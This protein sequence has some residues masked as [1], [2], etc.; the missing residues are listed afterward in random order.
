MKYNIHR[1]GTT[2]LILGAIFSYIYFSCSEPV[3]DDNNHNVAGFLHAD[4]KLIVDGNGNEIILRGMGFGG[5]MVQEP[6]MMLVSGSASAGQHTIFEDIENLIGSDNLETY[7]QTWLD[8]YCTEIDVA[9]LKQ[10]GFNSLRVAMHYNLF[11]LPIE[12]EPVYGEDT[13]LD[14]GFTMIDELLSW[15][16]S[17]RIYL[18]LDLHAAPGGQGHDAN[19][20]DYNP[21]RPS[22]WEHPQNRRKT[23]ALW[24]RLAE[25]YASEPWIGG[26][27]LINEPNWYLGDNNIM[28]KELYDDIIAEIRLVDQNHLI[29][30]EG[31]WFANDHS[32]LWPFEDDNVALSFHRYWCDNTVET[33]LGYLQMR[34]SYNVPLWMG[35]SGENNSQWYIDAVEL[36]EEYKIG[37]AWWTWKK[38]ESGTGIYSIKSPE[39]YNTLRNFWQ[40][41]GTKP[42]SAF[43]FKVMMSVAENALLK[44]CILNGETVL[45]LI[46]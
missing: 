2:I 46:K 44:N 4:G 7:H 16:E 11:T 26:Y 12:K 3:V 19:I 22:L 38:M 33:I 28:L 34:D 23:V 37:W 41:G 45:A 20:S 43:A 21:A 6:Y 1:K 9:Y 30:I 14:R 18:I 15:C 24:A 27:D 31:N 5:W 17:N 36:L 8:N 13:W 40:N 39:G 29:F 25:R 35:E 10:M 42:D 32:G